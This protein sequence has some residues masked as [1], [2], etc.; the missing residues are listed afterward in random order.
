VVTNERVGEIHYLTERQNNP[1]LAVTTYRWRAHCATCG[2]SWGGTEGH[3][4]MFPLLDD[5]RGY[6]WPTPEEGEK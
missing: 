4:G 5:I 6:G 3:P 2:E 1:W